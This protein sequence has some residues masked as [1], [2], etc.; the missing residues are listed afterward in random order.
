VTVSGGGT[1]R[2]F[3][4]S[5]SPGLAVTIANLTIAN[6]SVTGDESSTFG[7]GG[8]LNEAGCTLTLS[9][10]VL[11]NKTAKAANK[12]VDVFGGG[13]LNEGTAVV[14]SCTFSGNQAL[15]G[16][17][18]SFFGGFFA[19]SVGGAID[20]FEGATLTVTDSSFVHNQ[21]LGSGAGD[22]GIG[23]AIESNAL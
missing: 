11:K 7:G 9:H 21:A 20:N 17:G 6:G 10:A 15:G 12:T 19:G 23:G 4:I 14:A 16:G 5:G 1:T 3:D 18:G 13:L 2:V 22:F 8:I